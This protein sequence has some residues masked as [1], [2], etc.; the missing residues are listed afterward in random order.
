M[1]FGKYNGVDNKFRK[2]GGVQYNAT[3]NYVRNQIKD[4]GKLNVTEQIGEVNS[5]I[6][7]ES[8]IDMRGAS[9]LNL[10][11]LYYVEPSVVK[12]DTGKTGNTGTTYVPPY[13]SNTSTGIKIN[14]NLLVTNNM[15]CNNINIEQQNISN[16]NFG[17]V[18]LI[19]SDNY[20]YASVALTFQPISVI[21]SPIQLSTFSTT[22][23]SCSSSIISTSNGINIDIYVTSSTIGVS[24]IISNFFVSYLALTDNDSPLYPPPIN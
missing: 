22:N 20:A 8:H 18:S 1:S 6:C 17:T 16:I 9:F 23:I 24:D 3:N 13:I 15:K 2:Y 11:N 7:S 12:G 4:T 5:F 21:V 10:G 19:P 14:G